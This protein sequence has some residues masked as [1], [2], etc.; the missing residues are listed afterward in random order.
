MSNPYSAALDEEVKTIDANNPFNQQ[1]KEE[2]TQRPKGEEIRTKTPIIQE[3]RKSNNYFNLILDSD[4]RDI[5]LEIR[6]LRKVQFVNTETGKKTEEYELKENHYLTQDGAEFLITQLK[7]HTPA[8]MKLG[9]L[10]QD[11]FKITM[12]SFHEEFMDFIQDH[13]NILGMFSFEEQNK[14]LLLGLAIIN[15]VRAVYSR[16]IGGTENK[17]SHGDITLSGNL[18]SDKEDRF[19]LEDKRN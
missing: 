9:H 14:G 18:E 10:T 17:R 6:G 19:N 15:R 8:D 11:E 7:M 3:I 12:A 2:K 4:F 13:M 5:E 1:I 16:S